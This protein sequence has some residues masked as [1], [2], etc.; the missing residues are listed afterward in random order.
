MKKSGSTSGSRAQASRRRSA[1]QKKLFRH[2][3][4]FVE[5]SEACLDR[6][7]AVGIEKATEKF[8][9]QV[10]EAAAAGVEASVAWLSLGLWSFD[11]EERLICF[12]RMLKCLERE[13][14]KQ[15]STDAL[16]HWT[17]AY[18]NAFGRFEI[19]RA[20]VYQGRARDAKLFLEQALPFA[21]AAEDMEVRGE[22]FEGNIEGKIVGELLLLKA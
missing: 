22:A 18:Y 9:A 15:P 20:L 3:H 14:V 19:A 21:R 5:Q 16:G 7:D 11:N 10:A 6:D 2:W 13:E 12:G 1:I 17:Y 4:E 8:R